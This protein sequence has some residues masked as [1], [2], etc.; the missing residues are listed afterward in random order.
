MSQIESNLTERRIFTPSANLVQNSRVKGMKEY[1]SLCEAASENYEKLWEILGKSCDK[2]YRLEKK[3]H[4]N[5]KWREY[6]IL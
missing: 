1:L 3:V 6:T 4:K 2:T 5:F